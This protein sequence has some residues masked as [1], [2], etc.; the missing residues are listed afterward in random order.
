MKL[1]RQNALHRALWEIGE[2]LTKWGFKVS[3][4]I[5]LVVT[6]NGKQFYFREYLPKKEILAVL[7]REIRPYE[8]A[9]KAQKEKEA[10][11]YQNSLPKLL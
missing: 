11:D 9:E 3:P 1:F 5:R 7:R 2:D 10:Q 6:P 4:D 8:D